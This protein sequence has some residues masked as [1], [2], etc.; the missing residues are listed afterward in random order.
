MSCWSGT[1][2]GGQR[3][4][5]KQ[6]P[7]A[8]TRATGTGTKSCSNVP[9]SGRGRRT[10]ANCPL[11][12]SGLN[13]RCRRPPLIF[14]REW[15]PVPP[16]DLIRATSEDAN[17]PVRARGLCGG[18]SWPGDS[19]AGR[20]A[21]THH[22]DRPLQLPARSSRAIGQ[23]KV[24][25]AEPT[26]VVVKRRREVSN[27]VFCAQSTTATTTK[28]K[29]KKNKQKKKKKG[30]GGGRLLDMWLSNAVPSLFNSEPYRG[31]MQVIRS[32]V[33]LWV[34]LDWNP[35]VYPMVRWLRVQPFPRI[36]TYCRTLRCS[37][38]SCTPTS[39]ISRMKFVLS[40]RLL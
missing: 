4:L 22:P 36:R 33:V 19:Q 2:P 40:W 20:Q 24:I 10:H 9:A 14:I 23:P 6:G 12:K 8:R 15:C 37:V 21:K 1:E 16:V 39:G 38:T 11:E 25:P 30:I 18:E 28:K 7:A 31:E 3:G 35:E 27:L 17:G 13:P 29:R 32:E 34:F 26:F 5:R